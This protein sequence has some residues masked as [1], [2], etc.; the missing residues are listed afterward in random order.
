[1][2]ECKL[3]K[4]RSVINVR[5]V[6]GFCYTLASKWLHLNQKR[7]KMETTVQLRIAT[8]DDVT[9]LNSAGVRVWLHAKDFFFKN[10]AGNIEPYKVDPN[11]KDNL[12]KIK[13]ALDAGD[14]L[15]V[16]QD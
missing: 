14:L 2:S 3:L 5:N 8:I 4:T 6:R 16:S 1:M 13:A 7:Y 10:P 12:T 11:N 15:V 9:R